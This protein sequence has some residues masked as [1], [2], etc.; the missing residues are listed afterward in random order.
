M[1]KHEWLLRHYIYRGV[2]EWGDAT[3]PSTDTHSLLPAAVFHTRGACPILGSSRLTLVEFG[4]L[5]GS[6]NHHSLSWV[7]QSIP[8]NTFP[9]WDKIPC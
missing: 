3:W 5:S 1:H 9:N 6:Q 4:L 7:P 2:E 8:W